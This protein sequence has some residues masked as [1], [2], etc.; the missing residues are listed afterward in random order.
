[1]LQICAYQILLHLPHIRDGHLKG[2]IN[3]WLNLNGINR[4]A[5]W[6]HGFFCTKQHALCDG[7]T[8]KAGLSDKLCIHKP[9]VFQ[10]GQEILS[11]YGTALSLGPVIK[12][13]FRLLWQLTAQD[14]IGDHQP[15]AGPQH[16]QHL[17]QAPGLVGNQ[18]EDPVGYHHVKAIGGKG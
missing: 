7:G 4:L 12:P 2:R 5:F 1:M 3:C 18:V 9:N 11:R 6:R 13:G 10:K 17:R 15:P 8:V 16:P 14:L